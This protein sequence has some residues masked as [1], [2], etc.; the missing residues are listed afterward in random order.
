MVFLGFPRNWGVSEGKKEPVKVCHVIGQLANQSCSMR[1]VAN[2]SKLQEVVLGRIVFD[3]TENTE[4]SILV[5]LV[6]G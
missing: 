5:S 6:R 3:I 1:K 4:G 2:Q